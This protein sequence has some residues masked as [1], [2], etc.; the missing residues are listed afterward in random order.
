MSI[1]EV[2]WSPRQSAWVANLAPDGREGIFLALLS[3]KNLITA[4]PS[5]AL[6]GWL[7]SAF[8]PNC[9]QCRDAFGHFCS[10][11]RVVNASY[12]M[13]R[14]AGD[15]SCVGGDYSPRLHA[16]G[17]HAVSELHC[18][19]TCRDCPGWEGHAD[20]MW[21]IVLISSISSPLMIMLSIRFLR[22]DA[23]AHE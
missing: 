15:Y 6:N 20:T 2:I 8:Q 7:N 17:E 13:C 19:S 3:L 1:G 22:G 16:V 10:S 18:P 11:M 14:T 5:T 12:A 9:P 21:L 4:L 23:Q